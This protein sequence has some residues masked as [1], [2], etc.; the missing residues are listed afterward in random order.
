[1]IKITGIKLSPDTVK[2]G[3]QFK[4]TVTIEEKLEE[5]IAYRLPFIL[6]SPKGGI[7]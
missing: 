2:K 3:H 4:I 1:M 5:P 7:K 6:N